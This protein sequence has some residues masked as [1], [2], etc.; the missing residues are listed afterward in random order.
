MTTS[1][2][3]LKSVSQD[4]RID[5]LKKF[6]PARSPSND[7]NVPAP[8]GIDSAALKTEFTGKKTHDRSGASYPP[9]KTSTVDVDLK[10]VHEPSSKPIIEV[11]MD[12]GNCT[13]PCL[14]E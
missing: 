6:A 13:K 10:P 14:L 7:L 4:P 2:I 5:S 9:V 12:A 8:V 11:D 3:P 1:S